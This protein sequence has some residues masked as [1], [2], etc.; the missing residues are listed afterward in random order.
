LGGR[1][2]N[3]IFTGRKAWG[4]VKCIPLTIYIPVVNSFIRAF[5]QVYKGVHRE[6]KFNLAIKVLPSK[7]QAIE[8]EIELMKAMR[9]SSIVSYYG[10]CKTKN[11]IWV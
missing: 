11:N 2:R 8:K 10:T 3:C 1:S 5:G 4:R 7:D 6:S 9:N